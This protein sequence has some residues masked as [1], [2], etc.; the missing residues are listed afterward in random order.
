[1]DFVG[2]YQ[3]PVAHFQEISCEREGAAQDPSAHDRSATDDL[4]TA[5]S[6]IREEAPRGAQVECR[7]VIQGKC[8]A[9]RPAIRDEAYRIGR[10]ALLNAFRHSKAG[11]VEVDVEYAPKQFRI[12]VRDN[13]KGI[14]PDSFRVGCGGHRGLSGMRDLA[15]RMGAK[16]KLLSRAA[17]GTEVELSIPGHIAFAPQTNIRRSRSARA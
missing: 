4:E 9:L 1:M 3:E 6:R 13:G 7:M 11:R 14:T 10:E 12:A 16:L 8:R 2:S 17:G 15:E 5:F